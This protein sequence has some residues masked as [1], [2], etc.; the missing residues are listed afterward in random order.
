MRRTLAAII[1]AALLLLPGTSAAKTLT[2]HVLIP[3][4]IT[5]EDPDHAVVVAL[6]PPGDD[7]DD[8]CRNSRDVFDGPGCKPPPE[9]TPT[10][11]ASLSDGVASSTSASSSVQTAS[12]GCVGMEAE[13]GSAGYGAMSSTGYIGCYQISP[14]H[15][16]STGSCAGLGTDPAGQDACAAIICQTEGATAWTNSAGQ[17]PCGRL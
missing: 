1:T 2:N 16:N 8:G 14:D 10:T 6:V 17:N 3:H 12:A 7:D 13:S 11:A 4:G 5:R 9:P 15:Y